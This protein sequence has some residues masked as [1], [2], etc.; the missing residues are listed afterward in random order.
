[1]SWDDVVDLMWIFSSAAQYLCSPARRGAN[2]CEG[3]W[4]PSGRASVLCG[5][6]RL[7]PGGADPAFLLWYL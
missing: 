5:W 6:S 2:R 3:G 1:L 4:R 7:D